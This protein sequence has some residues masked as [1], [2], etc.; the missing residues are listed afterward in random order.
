MKVGTK[1]GFVNLIITTG[2][3]KNYRRKK[4]KGKSNTTLG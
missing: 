1:L 3:E 2:K 4:Y